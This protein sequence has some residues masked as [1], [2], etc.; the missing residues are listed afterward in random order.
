MS[1]PQSWK[2]GSSVTRQ[3]PQLPETIEEQLENVSD[4]HSCH[5]DGRQSLHQDDQL[6][7]VEA[8]L[9]SELS[10]ASAYSNP[11]DSSETVQHMETTV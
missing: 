11:R 10:F 3:L 7:Q 2:R 6:S 4:G 1:D 9:Q 5:D 8:D